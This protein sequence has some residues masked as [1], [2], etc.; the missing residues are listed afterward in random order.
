MSEFGERIRAARVSARPVD[1][2]I[3]LR[4]PLVEVSPPEPDPRRAEIARRDADG[5][6]LES[7]RR[8]VAELSRR[9]E[10]LNAGLLQEILR[11]PGGADEFPRTVAL[12]ADALAARAATN[13]H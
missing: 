6:A 10:A 7:Q 2:L 1:A 9:I 5:A 12:L 13:D 4:E 3:D 11:H 8:R